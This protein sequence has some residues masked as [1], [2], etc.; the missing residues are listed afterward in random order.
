MAKEEIRYVCEHCASAS[1]PTKKLADAHEARCLASKKHQ[2][3]IETRYDEMRKRLNVIR[4]ES[5]T[6]K[7]LADRTSELVKEV[8]GIKKFHFVFVDN[9]V[10]TQDNKK[11]SMNLQIQY[12]LGVKRKKYPFIS[13]SRDNE[14]DVRELLE[15][16]KMKTHCGSGD[17]KI[18]NYSTNF[19]ITDFPAIHK[20]MIELGVDRH[21]LE[22]AEHVARNAI[23]KEVKNDPVFGALSEELIEARNQLVKANDAYR[24]ALDNIK[25][26]LGSA[27]RELEKKIYDM[28]VD[29]LVDPIT[30]KI[31][32]NRTRH[33]IY[34]TD[35][36]EPIGYQLTPSI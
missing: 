27:S 30:G 26:P 9:S 23:I 18:Y 4:T 16:L 6:L 34:V 21:A 19:N 25:V 36:I 10:Y 7:E 5:S 31:A 33:S 17:G 29:H 1:F 22:S 28:P 2:E 20:R 32:V 35:V 13:W 14:L 3:R 15:T 11:Y 8:Y 12:Y 24:L